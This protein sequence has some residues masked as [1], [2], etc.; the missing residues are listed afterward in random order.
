MIAP[1]GASITPDSTTSGGTK[2]VAVTVNG[3][4]AAVLGDDNSDNNYYYGSV[5]T[6]VKPAGLKPQGGASA[7]G[8]TVM[9]SGI[10]L[11]PNPLNPLTPPVIN[12]GGHTI[13]ATCKVP[14]PLITTD[15]ISRWSNTAV[16]VVTPDS[17]T[18]GASQVAVTV[19]GG[20]SSLAIDNTFY[21]SSVVT[22]LAPQAGPATSTTTRATIT[23]SG[24]LT[25]PADMTVPPVVNWGSHTITQTCS[26]TVLTDCISKWSNLAVI[27]ISPDAATAGAT[28]SKQV[29]VTVNGG[30]RASS[31]DNNY[32]YESLVTGLKPQ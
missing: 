19:N 8:T 14:N 18:A 17:A 27:V 16:T 20:A 24:F 10:R 25:N 32:Y 11:L 13:T 12:W 7:G 30:T 22:A 26:P 21:Y 9:I 2:M 3:G 4:A 5:V 23:G 29:A 15:C 6:G 1:D 31:V 28:V